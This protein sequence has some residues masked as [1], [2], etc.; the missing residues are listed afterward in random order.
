MIICAG[1]SEQFDFASPIGIGLIDV[2]INLTKLCMDNLPES[3]LF[4]GTAGSY[5][6]IELMTIVQSSAAHNMEQAFLQDNS[7]SPIENFVSQDKNVSHE[8]ILNSSNYIC[9]NEE[10][11]KLYLEKDIQLEN[12]E[13][14]AVLKVAKEFNVPAKGIFIVT[15]YCN[16]NAHNDFKKNHKMAMVK[17]TEHISR[18]GIKDL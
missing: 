2:A 13:F 15:N 16:D 14:Y 9:T 17:L 11:A 8:T 10:I 1:E 12:M 5:G 4:V 7:Y 18:L 6:D 3:I